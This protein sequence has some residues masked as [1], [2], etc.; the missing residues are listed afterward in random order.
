MKYKLI[1]DTFLS[2][3]QKKEHKIIPS[4]PIYSNND[5][6]LFFIN[7]GMNPFKDY[8]LGH[9]KPDYSRIVNVQKCLRVTGKHNDLE[10]V[11]YDNYHHTMFEMLGNWSFGDYS[12]KE[13]IEWAWELL[14]DVYNIP[15]ENIYVSIFIGDKKEGLFMDD[16]TFKCWKNLIKKDNILFFGKEENFWEMGLTGPCGPCSEIH[17]DL[18]NEKEKKFLPGKNLVNKNH[19]R[20]IEIWNLVFIEFLRKSDGILEK[21]SKKHVDTGMGLERLCTV[22]QGKFSSYETDIFYPIIQTIKEFLGKIYKEDFHQKVSIHIIADHLRSIVFSISDGILPSNNGAGYVIRRIIRRS[23]IYAN[24]FLYQK[25]PFIY[26]FVDFLVNNMENDFPELENK[27]EHIKNVILEE[28]LSFLRVIEQGNQKIQH[29]IE[30]T[31]QKN[32]IIVDGKTIF[33]L[34]DTYGFPMRLSKILIEKNNMSID[35]KAFHE[36]LLEQR[37]RSKKGYIKKKDWIKVHDHQF[38]NGNISLVGFIGY[39]TIKCEILIVKYRKVENILEK[40]HYY[41]LVFSKTPFYPEGGGQLGDNGIIK[42]E[43][44]EIHIFNTKKENSIIIHYT[45]KLPSNVSS[46]FHAIVNQNRRSEIEKN[47]TSTHLLH[48]S[49]KDVLGNHIQQKGSYVGDEY[50]RFDFS[51]YKKI[52]LEE[53]HR[54]ENMVQKLIFSDLPL[55][56]RNFSSLQEARKNRSI[57]DTFEN[58]YKKGVRVITFGDSSELCIGTHVRHTGLI[59]IFK[60]ISETSVSY[61]IRRIKAI[62]SK[63]AIQYLK[64]I[65]DQYQSLKEMMKYPESPLKNFIDLQ[66]HNKELKKEISKIRLQQVNRIKKE[67]SLKI[68]QLSSINYLYDIDLFQE[69]E[70]D[71]NLVKK[72]VLDLRC[73]ISNLFMIVGFLRGG[74]PVVFISISDSVIKSQNIHAHKIICRIASYIHGKYWGNSFFAAAIGTKKDGLNLILKDAK[75]IKNQINFDRYLKCLNLE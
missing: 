68:I 53:L 62:T 57:S 41:E 47:H 46:H 72:I 7:A 22:L 29:I 70:L 48:F 71:M 18:R 20:V 1:K 49:L 5:P 6:T 34:Y 4:F 13:A 30:K 40:T 69:K 65:H 56:E 59:Q 25:G 16:E 44:D 51:H 63:K 38:I 36:K 27:E 58:K 14:I 28:E 19:P 39:D 74:K 2:F 8:F 52:S 54:I 35:E 73:E 64:S 24:R 67:Y 55:E 12:R 45:K 75:N 11:G 9:M 33:Q 66:K 37:N 60:I 32:E 61:G 3:F 23:I 50:L 10:N 15:E 42:N 31:K 26:Q 17:I 21:L 43:N